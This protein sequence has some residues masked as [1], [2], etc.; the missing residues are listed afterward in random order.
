MRKFPFH[1]NNY[2]GIKRRKGKKKTTNAWAL[3]Y[4][5]STLFCIVHKCQNKAV[6]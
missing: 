5:G 6:W 1:E 2:S 4:A 3:T